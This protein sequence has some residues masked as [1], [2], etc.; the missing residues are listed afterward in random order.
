MLYLMSQFLDKYLDHLVVTMATTV[1]TGTYPLPEAAQFT[2]QSD[3]ELAM[4]A[5]A[6]YCK[7][8]DLPGP[9]GVGRPLQSR[10]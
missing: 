4:K 9:N 1:S 8:A 6:G 3:F 5:Y 2:I 10:P 7:E